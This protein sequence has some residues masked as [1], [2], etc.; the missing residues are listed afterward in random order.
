M[1]HV[2]S[3]PLVTHT[4]HTCIECCTWSSTRRSHTNHPSI[5]HK[6]PHTYV[7][8]YTCTCIPKQIDMYLASDAYCRTDA[9]AVI[10]TCSI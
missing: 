4:F 9:V 1:L 5:S 10:Y 6:T 7:P 3:T 8:A 2:A